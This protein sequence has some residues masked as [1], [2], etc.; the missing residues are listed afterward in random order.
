MRP[1]LGAVSF[2]NT[3]PLVYTLERDPVH[4]DLSY[5]VPSRCATELASG[6]VDVGL[7]PTIEYA[8][9]AEPYSIAPGVAIATRG[10][11]LTVRLYYRG[12]V[13]DIE[14][15]ALDL[16][17]RK[18]R[19]GPRLRRRRAQFRGDAGDCGCGAGYR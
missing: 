17:S 8:R 12:D 19:A 14:K 18:I 11:V 3:R 9:S 13:Q 7:I 15:V 6:A 5:S 1:R 4:F 16:S 2:L 10:A